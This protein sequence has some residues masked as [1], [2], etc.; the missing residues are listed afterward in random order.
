MAFSTPSVPARPVA[1]RTVGRG[2]RGARA[3]LS[4]LAAEDRV[5]GLYLR[6]GRQALARRWRGRGGEIDLI[7]RDGDTVVFIEVKQSRTHAQAAEHLLPAQ[8]RR[9]FL[10]AEEFVGTLPLGGLTPVRFDVALVD[11]QGCIEVIENALAA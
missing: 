1:G 6:S 8:V 10:A 4:G 7:F 2:L 3:H 9:L 11:G 5:E